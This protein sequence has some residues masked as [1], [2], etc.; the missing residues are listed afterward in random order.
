MIET[1]FGDINCETDVKELDLNENVSVDLYWTSLE[2][3]WFGDF[4]A[5]LRYENEDYERGRGHGCSINEGQGNVFGGGSGT[6][7]VYFYGHS[8]GDGDTLL[9]EVHQCGDWLEVHF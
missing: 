3:F 7:F 8:S 2:G 1:L 4:I 6:G 9:D 5:W